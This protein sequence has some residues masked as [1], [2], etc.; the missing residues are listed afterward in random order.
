[1]E[2]SIEEQKKT[3]ESGKESEQIV[4][5]ETAKDNPIYPMVCSLGWNPQY[6]NET[7]TLEVHIMHNFG[8]DFYGSLIRI[9]ICGYIRPEKKFESVQKLI[10]AIH[11]DIDFARE[12]LDQP[13]K[14]WKH[15][16]NERFFEL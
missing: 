1:M 6:N 14:N 3:K 16:V 2:K 9:A 7:R 13:T 12:A 4:V 5:L 10:D 8:F 15:V 11:E